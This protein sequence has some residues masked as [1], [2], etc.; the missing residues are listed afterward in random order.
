[1][2][3]YENVHSCV[4]FPSLCESSTENSILQT[5]FKVDNIVTHVKLDSQHKNYF[6]DGNELC[7][8]KWIPFLRSRFLAVYTKAQNFLCQTNAVMKCS[9][10]WGFDRH[11]ERHS[12]QARCFD[13]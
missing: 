3:Q 1:M 9:C 5:G 11:G 6:V 4:L 8:L 13:F 10:G 7:R 2:K 12:A